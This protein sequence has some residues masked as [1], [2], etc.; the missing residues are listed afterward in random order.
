MSRKK[1]KK[2]AKKK[3]ILTFFFADKA[4]PNLLY[5]RVSSCRICSVNLATIFAR[6]FFF[7]RGLAVA[8][9]NF[10]ILITSSE[11]SRISYVLR[12]TKY[13]SRLCTLR[14]DI[15]CS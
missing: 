12:E 14:Y 8:Y 11:W 2:F 3:R 15:K 1:S 9:Y 5:L 13:L 4:L 7:W 6:G 10:I